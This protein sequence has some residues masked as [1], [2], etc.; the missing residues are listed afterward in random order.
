[1]L[2]Q[3]LETPNPHSM[4]FVPPCAVRGDKESLFFRKQDSTD[5]SPFA[6]RILDI[7]H[8]SAVFLGA[9]F[10]TVTKA[11][12]A[13]WY[14]LKPSVLGVM[15]EFFTN[16]QPLVTQEKERAPQPDYASLEEKQQAHGCGG[17]SVAMDQTASCSVPESETGQIVDEIIALLEDRVR[18]AV[19]QDGGDIVFRSF[20]DGIVY[21]SLQGACSGCPSSRVTLKN[22]VENMLK[23]YVPEVKE[24][25]AV[26]S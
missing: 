16:N 15:V 23:Y 4:K 11:P 18:P 21:L 20:A 22:G 10:I 12:E 14:T 25:R 2:I 26:E 3:S 1:M 8:I 6:K 24:V 9:D 19:A 13:D 17:G 5:T 7:E